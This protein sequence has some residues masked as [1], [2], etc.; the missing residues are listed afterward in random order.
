MR[1][2]KTLAYLLFD[3]F[4]RSFQIYPFILSQNLPQLSIRPR[5][6]GFASNRLDVKYWY[7]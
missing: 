6:H 1:F 5:N 4:E 7:E 3:N 2:Q